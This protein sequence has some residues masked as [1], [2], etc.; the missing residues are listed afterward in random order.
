M[1]DIY[2]GRTIRSV[3]GGADDI[4]CSHT[5][6]RNCNGKESNSMYLMRCVCVARAVK[7]IG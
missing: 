6:I 5:A 2:D 7:M 1:N 4:F 3:S